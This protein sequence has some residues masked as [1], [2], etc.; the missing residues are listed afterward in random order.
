MTI[1]DK[2]RTWKEAMVAFFYDTIPWLGCGNVKDGEEIISIKNSRARD[3]NQ[4]PGPPN[5]YEC[6]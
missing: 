4:N 1:N 5:K 6:P 2:Q 3:L